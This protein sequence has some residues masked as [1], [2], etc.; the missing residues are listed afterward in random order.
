MRT[1]HRVVV[2]DDQPLVRDGL[3]ALLTEP[4]FEIV[5]EAAGGAE[6]VAVVAET[7]PDVVIM[8][9]QMPE[10]SGIEATAAVTAAN[11]NV[12]VLV[13]TMFEGDD[14]VF[15]A[16]R[17]G[18]RG[19]LLKGAD[20][21]EV[22][23]AI[24]TV[25]SGGAVFGPTVAARVIDF[26]AVSPPKEVVCPELTEREREVLDLIARGMSN[27]EISDHLVVSV[28]TVANHVSNIFAKLHVADRARAIV[29]AREVGLGKKSPLG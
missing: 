29:K 27:R 11:P 22:V 25:A 9:L 24:E 4:D 28:K 19:Y 15:A 1:P 21:E 12:A 8:D 5:G 23:R 26:F 13:L 10:M 20:H 16:M 17:A 3:R 7:S 6:A 18:A 14:S 2:A